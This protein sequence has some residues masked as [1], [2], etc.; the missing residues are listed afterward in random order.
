MIHEHTHQWKIN[1]QLYINRKEREAYNQAL[2]LI[3]SP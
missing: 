3:G 1:M 2:M